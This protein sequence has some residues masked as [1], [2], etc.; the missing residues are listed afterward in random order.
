MIGGNLV[1][2][3]LWVTRN[4]VTRRLRDLYVDDCNNDHQKLSAT[5][6]GLTLEEIEEIGVKVQRS[7]E[8]AKAYLFLGDE[9]LSTLDEITKK[10]YEVLMLSDRKNILSRFHEKHGV[11]DY[12][13]YVNINTKALKILGL[14]APPDTEASIKG[15]QFS[16]VRS[17]IKAALKGAEGAKDEWRMWASINLRHKKKLMHLEEKIYHTDLVAMTTH[18]VLKKKGVR[19]IARKGAYVMYLLGYSNQVPRQNKKVAR[20]KACKFFNNKLDDAKI[21]RVDFDHTETS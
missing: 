5:L 2:D 11:D 12:P 8:R 3:H 21:Y 10:L 14:L 13:G 1:F 15:K 17:S 16:L 7:V 20:D 18:G 4:E 6:T 19:D 9:V